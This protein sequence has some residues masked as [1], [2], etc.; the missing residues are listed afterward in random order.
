MMM[1]LEE[2]VVPLAVSQMETSGYQVEFE[3]LGAVHVGED[4]PLKQAVICLTECFPLIALQHP[5]QSTV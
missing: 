5:T 2:L 1:R 3:H 4:I